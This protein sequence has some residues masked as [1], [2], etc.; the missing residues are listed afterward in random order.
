M[1][2]ARSTSIKEKIEYS[3]WA[4]MGATQMS[5][6]VYEQNGLKQS[7]SKIVLLILIKDMVYFNFN[8]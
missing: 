1:L 5:S 3:K 8:L 2:I 6:R 4:E 7:K